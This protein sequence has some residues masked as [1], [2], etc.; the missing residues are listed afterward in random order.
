MLKLFC[1]ICNNEVQ[2]GEL[3]GEFTYLESGSILKQK[4]PVAGKYQLCQACT[5]E[6]KNKLT[7]MLNE[8]Q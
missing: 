7:E 6:V 2:A 3:G 5:N 4:K 8:K 1:D